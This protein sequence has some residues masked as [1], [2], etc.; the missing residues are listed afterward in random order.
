M[1]AGGIEPHAGFRLPRKCLILLRNQ[2]VL[3]I[4]R[5]ITTAPKRPKKTPTIPKSGPGPVDEKEPPKLITGRSKVPSSAAHQIFNIHGLSPESGEQASRQTVVG[6]RLEYGFFTVS[7]A[8]GGARLRVNS[9]ISRK[10]IMQQERCNSGAVERT[11]AT[12]RNPVA[13]ALMRIVIPHGKMLR[14]SVVP[15]SH[16]P[17]LPGEA[18]LKRGIFNVTKEHL[19]YRAA[20]GLT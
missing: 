20:F 14:A 11:I 15:E 1:E 4:L 19:K 12:N 5:K 6:S 2:E 10:V 3:V 18:A 16:R 9:T 7:K 13:I 17:R 8:F